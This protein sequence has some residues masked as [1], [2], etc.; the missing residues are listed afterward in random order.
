MQYKFGGTPPT[1]TA[2]PASDGVEL[3]WRIEGNECWCPVGDRA[4]WLEI[5]QAAVGRRWDDEQA[6]WIIPCESLLTVL[7]MI[8]APVI[9]VATQAYT[10]HYE[11]HWTTTPFDHQRAAVDFGLAHERWM[12]ADSQGLGKTAVGIQLA[13]ERKLRGEIQHCLVISC[14]NL[15]QYNWR[16]ECRRLGQSST[17]LGL[18]MTRNGEREGG[19][20]AKIEQIN[21]RPDAF[22]WIINVEALRNPAV[23]EALQ[24][25]LRDGTIGMIIADESHRLK[26]PEA[27]QSRGFL[28]LVARYGLC[29]TGTPLVNSPLDFY[30]SLRWLGI[31]QRTWWSFSHRY[32]RWSERFPKIIGYQRLE[33]LQAN[34]QRVLLRRRKEDVLN[35]PPKIVSTVYCDLEPGQKEL[36]KE[37]RQYISTHLD[38]IKL[39][40]NPLS[41]LIRLRQCTGTPSLL[42]GRDMPSG[43]LL[44]LEDMLQTVEGSALIFTNW[45]EAAKILHKKFGGALIYGDIPVAERAAIVERFQRGEETLLIGTL[46]ALGMGVTLT[47]AETA[48]FFDSPWTRA[49]QEQGED[50]IYRIGTKGTVNIYKLVTKG[51][52]DER[53]EEIVSQKGAWSDLMVDPDRLPVTK[54]NELLQWLL[55]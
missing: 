44:A 8:G 4:D 39:S 35:L 20:A 50:R 9:I 45:A 5:L 42:V 28:R 37:I 34:V 31:E 52:I 13:V 19:T 24:A 49:M 30:V 6:C 38:E 43:K 18:V 25:A 41:Q 2:A 10:G 11:Q 51:T 12:L 16:E 26:N 21:A 33:E 48:F 55:S 36:Y 15:V 23:V 47:A 29:L 1:P 27:K 46:E 22:F 53:V 54:R 40:P 3:H 32:A 17:I 7:P 14:V